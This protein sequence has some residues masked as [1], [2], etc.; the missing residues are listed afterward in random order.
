[1]RSKHEGSS[2]T[3]RRKSSYWDNQIPQIQSSLDQVLTGLVATPSADRSA[4]GVVQSAQAGP[5]YGRWFTELSLEKNQATGYSAFFENGSQADAGVVVWHPVNLIENEDVTIAV[6]SE[7]LMSTWE[8]ETDNSKLDFIVDGQ[9]QPQIR[10][11]DALT[12]LFDTAGD[13]TVTCLHYKSGMTYTLNVHVVEATLPQDLAV[14]ELRYNTVEL[15]D[16][17]S[18]LRLDSGGEIGIGSLTSRVLGGSEVALSGLFPGQH[19]MAVRMADKATILDQKQVTVIG[20]SDALR[21]QSDVVIPVGDN[22]FRITSPL[23][24]T[25]MPAGA[26]VKITIFAGGVT[27][28]DG[29]TLKTLTAANFDSNGLYILELLMPVER[30]GAPCHRIEIFD[31]NGNK[32]YGN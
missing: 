8:S 26:T 5:G 4:A 14:A 18:D 3:I 21:N 15:P 13:F 28:L 10:A 19:R 12:W 7:L 11:H 17:S 24:I 23:L 9:A 20:V 16:V 31:A 6:H 29:T 2:S 22:T 25:N 32:I 1:M 30:L 27:F